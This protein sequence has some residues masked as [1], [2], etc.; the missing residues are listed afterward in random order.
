VVAQQILSAQ[1]PFMQ[2]LSALH[3]CP[4]TLSPQVPT[5]CPLGIVQVWPGAQ[6]AADLHDS[7]QAPA[8]QAKLPQVKLLAGWQVP[9][10]SHARAELPA[11]GLTQAASAQGVLAG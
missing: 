5:V 11:I 8:V 7:V 4:S 6:S 1:W 2:S 10:P 9:S 3:D